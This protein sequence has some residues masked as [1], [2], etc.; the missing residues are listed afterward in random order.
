MNAPK[1]TPDALELA[2]KV[3]ANKSNY[4][5]AQTIDMALDEITNLRRLLDAAD[6]R[7]AVNAALK[8]SAR[9]SRDAA[10]A[11]LSDLLDLYQSAYLTGAD[12]AVNPQHHGSPRIG[13]SDAPMNA[14]PHT[15]EAPMTTTND[16]A[17]D[18]STDRFPSAQSRCGHPAG[19]AA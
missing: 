3:I 12:V 16:K 19:V 9:E 17:K 11:L 7:A 14:H 13:R 10:L 5:D 1:H 15:A 2:L 6:R 8:E 18:V 4:I